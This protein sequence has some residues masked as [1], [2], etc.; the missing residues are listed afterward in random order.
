M[1]EDWTHRQQY[2]RESSDY[3]L[4]L[5][6]RWM[7]SPKGESVPF[8]APVPHYQDFIGN[9]GTNIDEIQ[10][11]QR[12][13][14]SH[15]PLRVPESGEQILRER[16]AWRK[17]LEEG[18]EDLYLWGSIGMGIK[19]KEKWIVIYLQKRLWLICK[20]RDGSLEI[21]HIEVSPERYSAISHQQLTFLR[22]RQGE[23]PWFWSGGSEQSTSECTT[24][25]MWLATYQVEGT[26]KLMVAETV[27][28]LPALLLAT[29]L[30]ILY[31]CLSVVV[32][33]TIGAW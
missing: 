17:F 19:Q 3:Y 18:S 1:P 11:Q 25:N 12:R 31:C 15:T 7:G 21:S 10:L 13:G 27:P 28:T 30:I 5:D 23:G 20:R 6:P 2:L 4:V 8:Q 16:P 29:I 24:E 32:V 26:P 9:W 33:M 22:R 14:I